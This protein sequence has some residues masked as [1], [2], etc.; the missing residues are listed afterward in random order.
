M[1]EARMRRPIYHFGDFILDLER[2]ALF[3]AS[4]SEVSLRPKA[5]SLLRLFVENAGRLIDRGM[6]IE[7]L[8][9]GTFVTDESVAQCIKDV[10]RALGDEAQHLVKTVRGRGYRLEATV[11]CGERGPRQ[12]S[13][14]AADLRAVGKRDEDESP[15]H[16][17]GDDIAAHGTAQQKPS[18]D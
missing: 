6:I 3:A 18:G 4:G 5:F 7:A 16:V 12:L 11:V 15:E 8:W 13:D 2:G 1:N 14:P 10:R 9:S 17:R